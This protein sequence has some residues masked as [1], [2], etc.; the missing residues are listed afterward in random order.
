MALA[1]TKGAHASIKLDAFLRST[2]AGYQHA[3]AQTQGDRFIRKMATYG[4]VRP[5]VSFTNEPRVA[6]PAKAQSMMDA[7][8]LHP[9][10]NDPRNDPREGNFEIP[11]PPKEVDQT[12]VKLYENQSLMLPS[13][14]YK[15]H[16]YMKQAKQKYDED[17]NAI[18]MYNKRVTTLERKHAEGITGID[19]PLFPDSKLYGDSHHKVVAQAESKIRHAEGRY[20]ILADKSQSSDAVAMRDWGTDPNLP[21]SRDLCIQRKRIDPAAHPFRFMNSHER[22]FPSYI[23]AW[24]PDRAAALRSH[25]VRDR[26]HNIITGVS[27]DLALRVAPT[28]EDLVPD[29]VSFR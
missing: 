28:V 14:R 2:D 15:E 8:V 21:R 26:G 18:F 10:W 3:E 25:D 22:L 27:N 12:F 20:D 4:Q 6:R 9:Q 24:D 1:S 19:G 17:R 16:L 29:F 13:E 7:S 5:S 11:Q 23:P